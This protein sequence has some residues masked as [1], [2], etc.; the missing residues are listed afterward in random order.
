MNPNTEYEKFAQETY[1]RLINADGIKTINVQH[2]VKLVG[3]SGQEHQIDVY[4]EYEY[5]GIKH[6]VAIECKNYN[7]VVPIGKVRDFYGVLSD[8]NNVAGIMV[9]KIGYQDGA[10]KYAN[11]YG[12]GLKELRSPNR[13]EAIVGEIKLSFNIGIRHRLFLIDAEWARANN[14]N[15]DKYRDYLDS[16]D[17]FSWPPREPGIIW[18]TETHIPLETTRNAN[19]CNKSGKTLTTFD[20][21][22]S[23]LPN[24]IGSGPDYSF[25]FEDAY[26]NTTYWGMVKIKEVKYTHEKDKQ[27]TVIS[28]DAQEFVK[29]ILKDALSGEIQFISKNETI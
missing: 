11:T 5:A 23:K 26:V 10:K 24:N 3:K 27:T 15:F 21:L 4:W 13:G 22:E 14:L 7:S 25:E 28:I 18:K 8:L 19:I 2:N 16:M 20:E 1:Q 9:T 12:I 6:K 29:A 17:N